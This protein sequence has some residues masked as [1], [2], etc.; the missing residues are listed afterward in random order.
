MKSAG[1]SLC[2]AKG[3]WN[4]RILTM[5]LGSSSGALFWF[6]P[7]SSWHTVSSCSAVRWHIHKCTQGS[8]PSRFAIRTGIP[9]K[10]KVLP[11]I[12]DAQSLDKWLFKKCLLYE[13]WHTSLKDYNHSLWH[14]NRHCWHHDTDEKT[15]AQSP[16]FSWG[17]GCSSQRDWY[18]IKSDNYVVLQRKFATDFFTL[19]RWPYKLETTWFE[20]GSYELWVNN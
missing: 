4:V 11:F 20:R 16:A 14:K 17:L 12:W 5:I 3:H 8:F 19:S 9:P 2:P 1:P 18:I 6:C 13:W 7:L 10:L 15:G